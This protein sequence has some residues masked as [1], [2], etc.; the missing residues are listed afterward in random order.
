MS[1]V[2]GLKLNSI[3][4]LLL[5]AMFVLGGFASLT[6]LE[7]AANAQA[8]EDA[9]MNAVDSAVKSGSDSVAGPDAVEC[10]ELLAKYG[11]SDNKIESTFK[12]WNSNH[13]VLNLKEDTSPTDARSQSDRVDD[14]DDDRPD[15]QGDDR[16]DDQDRR[17]A[18]DV[19]DRIERLRQSIRDRMD[20]DRDG[21]REEIARH[22]VELRASCAEGDREDC[23]ELR[24]ILER[25]GDDDERHGDER[26]D[27]R[28]HRHHRGHWGDW[29]ERDHRD[30]RGGEEVSPRFTFPDDLDEEHAAILKQCLQ[31]IVVDVHP[32]AI[33]DSDWR[34]A[35]GFTPLE[36]E[37]DETRERDPTRD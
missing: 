35:A 33:S 9:D 17:D 26:Q 34:N 37:W 12:L 14:S 32:A 1:G 31:H 30:Y 15:E 24:E 22:I 10:Q 5:V 19:R 36:R 4:S 16:V 8:E 29:G 23:A 27:R 21:Q 13:Q 20:R 6:S 2:S 18:Q 28:G 11:K 7:T 3:L 25:L